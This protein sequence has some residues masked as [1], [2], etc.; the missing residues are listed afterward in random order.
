M[1]TL[2]VRPSRWTAS[3]IGGLG[4]AGCLATSEGYLDRIVDRGDAAPPDIQF[5][6]DASLEPQDEA[7]ELPDRAAHAVN[8]VDPAHG[9][10]AGGQRALVRGN[11]FSSEA[12][13]WFGATEVPASETLAADARR[14]QVSV[15]AGSAGAVD[16]TVQNGADESTRRTL[17]DAYVY[18][19]FYVEPPSGPV[20]G[21]T[22][23]TLFGDGTDWTD[24]TRVLVDREPCAVTALRSP[25]GAPQQI[26]CRVPPGTP[27][28]KAVRV[29]TGDRVDEVL[30]AYVYGDSE[31]GFRGGLSGDPLDGELRVLVLDSYTGN[32][33]PGA[34]IIVGDA[35][36]RV[37]HADESG[38]TVVEDPA[39]GP[40]QTVTI[41]AR[42]HMPITFVDVP[43]DTVTAY[44]DPIQTP[45]C[46]D[47]SDPHLLG[48]GGV[49]RA[50]S[51]I[52]G[53]LIWR[54]GVEFKRAPWLNVPYP[55]S[56][57]AER[58]AYVFG[59]E[60]APTRPFRLP[61]RSLGVTPE[62]DGSLGY[63]FRFSAGTGNLTLYALAGVERNSDPGPRQ[64]TAYAMGLVRG[65]SAEPG[66]TTENVYITMDNT[67][68]HAIVMSVHPP[69]P[70]ARG[71]DRLVASVAVRV[72]DRGYAI[73]PASTE[74]RLLPLSGDLHFVGLPPLVRSL[75]GTQLV[76]TAVANT[77]EGGSSPRSV[78]GQFATRSSSQAVALDGFLEV[79]ELDAPGENEV[80]DGTEL[81]FSAAP[82]GP[83]ADLTVIEIH[84][85]GSLSTWVVAVPS[86]DGTVRLPDLRAVGAK[87]SP[88]SGPVTLEISRARIDAFDYGSLRYVHLGP[89]GWDAY[90]QDT[91]QASW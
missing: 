3:L 82:G 17:K 84:G 63:A 62:T 74:T 83:E 51:T 27:G 21:G 43:V 32:P 70:T 10:F 55:A 89:R 91:Y 34:T 23:V 46:I 58:V 42:C 73:L 48:S 50:T 38:V 36:D 41:A 86:G 69:T 1:S 67:L 28:S 40:R 71:P 44:L 68:D 64:F 88:P 77:G 13:V 78:L 35:I 2:I 24:S 31:N 54:G 4:V 14:I 72:T 80:W 26:D 5:L 56:D 29:E 66:R 11:G 19:T 61:S 9:S 60:S 30:D 18:D 87:L 76:S 90:A 47:L 52:E 49:P 79:P 16:V 39:L 6:A 81:T 12:R 75:G 33:L 20:S 15:P 8:G 85:G 57:D 22:L 7:V 59:L 65:V 45:A 37:L 53:E 25:P